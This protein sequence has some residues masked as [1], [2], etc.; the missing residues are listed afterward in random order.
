VGKEENC[1]F[2]VV[3]GIDHR[4]HPPHLYL[5]LAWFP[6]RN[7]LRQT[8]LNNFLFNKTTLTTSYPNAVFLIAPRTTEPPRTDEFVSTSNNMAATVQGSVKW[9]SNKKGYGF[10]TPAE[11]SPDTE[12]IFVHQSSIFCEGYRTLVS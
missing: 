1:G 8:Q 11:G 9:F 4:H 2:D 10:I 6:L 3:V 5:L 7:L 12:D